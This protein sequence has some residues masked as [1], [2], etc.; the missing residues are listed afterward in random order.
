VVIVKNVTGGLE[1]LGI[2]LVVLAAGWQVALHVG[3]PLGLCSSA[4]A[5]WL[6]SWLLQGARLPRVRRPDPKGIRR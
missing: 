4:V 3:V 6:A 5:A 1:L 2:L